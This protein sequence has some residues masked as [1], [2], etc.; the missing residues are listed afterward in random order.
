MQSHQLNNSIS[1]TQYSFAKSTRFVTPK[2]NT[3]SF[4]EV[5]PTGFSTLQRKGLGSGF[6]SSADRFLKVKCQSVNRV[7]GPGDL[8]KRG[9]GF[10]KGV[11]AY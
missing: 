9:N 11:A 5:Y 1:K 8:D 6:N 7:D 4:A 3:K 10:V 2:P